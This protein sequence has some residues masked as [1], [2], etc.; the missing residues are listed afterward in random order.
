MSRFVGHI[1]AFILAGLVSA[2]CSLYDDPIGVVIENDVPVVLSLNIALSDGPAVKGYEDPEFSGEMMQ[3]LRIII[4]R[5]DG[6]VEHNRF[7]DLASD[8]KLLV[9]NQKFEVKGNELKDVYLI[10]NESNPKALASF[11]FSLIP[12][13]G[14]LDRERMASLTMSMSDEWDSVQLPVPMTASY[15]IMM[16]QTDKAADLNIFRA[17]AKFTFRF[18]NETEYTYDLTQIKIGKAADNEFF[19]PSGMALQ[20]N[21][22]TAFEMPEDAAYYDFIKTYDHELILRWAGTDKLNAPDICILDPVYILEGNHEDPASDGKNY[23]V[24][25]IINGREFSKYLPDLPLLPRNTHAVV[26]AKLTEK[27]VLD[28]FDVQFDVDVRPYMEVPYGDVELEP[29]FGL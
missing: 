3:T 13:G 12:A 26:T 4:V 19:F 2:G 16:P 6:V 15:Q 8:P 21:V 24:S 28:W 10:A 25:F 9:G 11:D 1:L 18:I 22:I 14:M 20:N 29:G 17:V 5:P 23:K 7:L 27:G